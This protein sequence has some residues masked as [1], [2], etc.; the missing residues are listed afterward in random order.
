MSTFA[1][2]PGLSEAGHLRTWASLGTVG[3]GGKGCDHQTSGQAA[4]QQP[5]GWGGAQGPGEMGYR[6]VWGGVKYL[7]Q[8]FLF[9]V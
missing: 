6:Q 5:T 8:A 7:S 4:G 2:P 1:G 3:V 9:H